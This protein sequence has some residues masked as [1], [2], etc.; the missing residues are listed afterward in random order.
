M[1]TGPASSYGETRPH[2]ASAS[3]PR[4]FPA[5][6]AGTDPAEAAVLSIEDMETFQLF[7]AEMFDPSIFEGFQ[8]SPVEGVALANGLWENEPYGGGF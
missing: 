1:K 5:H 3:G 4:G 7:T 8:Q 6:A 2:A